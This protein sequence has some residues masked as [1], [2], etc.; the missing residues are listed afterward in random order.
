MNPF[1]R[2]RP[3]DDPAV[4]VVA[5]PHAGGSAAAYFPLLPAIPAN[6]DLLL[7]D[8]PGRGK[9]HRLPPL[10]NMTRIVATA[11]ADLRPWT[12]PPLALFGHSMGAIV[13]T[14]VA[15]DLVSRG[16]APAW[17]GVSGRA[18]PGSGSAHAA[19]SHRLSDAELLRSLAEMGGL[20]DR[21]A[22][23]PEFRD[24][25]LSL[26]R[27]DLTAVDGYRPPAGR[28]PLPVP[29]TAFG[30]IDDVWAPPG[31]VAA[32]RQETTGPFRLRWFT[33]GHFHFVRSGF[34]EFADVVRTEIALAVTAP[35]PATGPGRPTP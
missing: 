26:V 29:L 21:L 13:A 25:L 23:V 17:L 8:L 30:A 34:R 1:V 3:V 12:G 31:A 19:P 32:W 33:G 14:E 27:A 35:V 7:L 4:R 24:R 10:P 16:I 6:W 22:E 20:P 2:P 28:D 18:A 9:R 11:V 5:V 15:H